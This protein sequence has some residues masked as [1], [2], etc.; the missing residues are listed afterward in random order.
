MDYIMDVQWKNGCW[1][2]H[3]SIRKGYYEHLTFNEGV[4]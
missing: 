4:N 2:Q 3:Y 1:P